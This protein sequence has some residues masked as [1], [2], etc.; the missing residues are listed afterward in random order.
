MSGKNGR[1]PGSWFLA[2]PRLPI[3]NGQ[4]HRAASLPTHSGGTAPD[5]H[6]TSLLTFVPDDTKDRFHRIHLWLH[7]TGKPARLTRGFVRAHPERNCC[8]PLGKEA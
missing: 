6:R 3:R 8:N 1:S 7:Y 4:W 5:S 2:P